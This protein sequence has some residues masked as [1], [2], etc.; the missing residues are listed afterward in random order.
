[1]DEKQIEL[2]NYHDLALPFCLLSASFF[3]FHVNVFTWLFF[4]T[5]PSVLL[6]R[7]SDSSTFA[8]N[9]SPLCWL[10][11]LLSAAGSVLL[12]R[13]LMYQ[14]VV[15]KPAIVLCAIFGVIIISSVFTTVM[16]VPGLPTYAGSIAVVAYASLPMCLAY[17]LMGFENDDVINTGS[18]NLRSLAMI[19]GIY[20]V[21]FTLLLV[22][23]SSTYVPPDPDPRHDNFFDNFNRDLLWALFDYIDAPFLMPAVGLLLFRM[24]IRMRRIHSTHRPDPWHR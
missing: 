2:V 23:F 12:L 4:G 7:F 21:F 11:L 5:P 24:G 16:P 10:L 17:L 19:V 20:G 3:L 9:F 6:I 14:P 22:H 8:A 13:A 18:G 15:K 1:M